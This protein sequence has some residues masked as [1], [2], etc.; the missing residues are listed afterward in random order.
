M[1]ATVITYYQNR[2]PHTY[3]KNVQHYL[4]GREWACDYVYKQRGRANALPDDDPSERPV[5]S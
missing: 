5:G 4:E 3:S 1:Y 2:K